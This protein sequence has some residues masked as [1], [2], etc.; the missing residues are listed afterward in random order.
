MD[1]YGLI[2]DRLQASINMDAINGNNQERAV[3][4]LQIQ[5]AIYELRKLRNAYY[6][7]EVID[8]EPTSR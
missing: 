1:K 4:G 8:H 6:S 2:E 7:R 3:L 5:E